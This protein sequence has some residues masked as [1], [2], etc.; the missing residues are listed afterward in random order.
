[1]RK[2]T[3]F[4]LVIALS[5]LFIAGCGGRTSS[6]GYVDMQKVF[7]ES[8]KVKDLQTQMET[9]QKELLEQAQQEEGTMP[10]EEFDKK[11]QER[12]ME[13]MAFSQDIQKQFE[14]TLKQAID[15]VAKEKQL[16]AILVKDNIL[17]GGVDVTDDVIKK[18]Q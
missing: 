4:A 1:M 9:K 11:Q 17:S 15:E 8:Q 5:A 7:Q 3:L 18:I 10:Q 16:G 13:F 14:T 6:F 12:N 2:I